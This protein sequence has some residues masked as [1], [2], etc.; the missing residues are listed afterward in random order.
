MT[1]DPVQCSFPGC[2]KT[3]WGHG[4]CNSHNKQRLQGKSLGS[5]RRRLARS[6]LSAVPVRMTIEEKG[7]VRKAAAKTNQAM[8][9]LLRDAGVEAARTILESRQ[10]EVDG[11]NNPA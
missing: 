6:S 5:L 9:S 8:G 1:K 7:L 10:I 4:L 3:V 2:T 11:K